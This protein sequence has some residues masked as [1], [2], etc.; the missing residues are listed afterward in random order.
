VLVH[1]E[2]WN[3][4]ITTKFNIAFVNSICDLKRQDFNIEVEDTT[5]DGIE[6]QSLDW[7]Q[8]AGSRIHLQRKT[9]MQGSSATHEL[10]YI[11]KIYQTAAVVN[12]PAAQAHS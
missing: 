9:S 3:R 6:R 2:G 10:P 12:R 5:E 8:K 11:G 7:C 1:Y 4:E